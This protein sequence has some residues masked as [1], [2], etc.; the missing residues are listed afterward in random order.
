MKQVGLGFKQYVQDF[1]GKYP[2]V[3]SGPRR[4]MGSKGKKG[5]MESLQPYLKAITLFQCPSK[6]K[7]SA[8]GNIDY[9]YNSRLAGQRADKLLYSANTVLIGDGI[10]D[11]P[12]NASL[13]QLP[14]SWLAD[15]NS[16]AYRHLNAA[17]YAFADGHVKWLNPTEI[18][19]EKASNS[20]N[21]FAPW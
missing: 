4:W 6:T 19:N 5:W 14:A 18:T 17:N 21:T 8:Y 1:D 11:A 7:A 9:F 16:P 3:T 13:S 12:S 20:V 2:L 10:P 15:S